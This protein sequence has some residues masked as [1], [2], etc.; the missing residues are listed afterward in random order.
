MTSTPPFRALAVVPTY[1]THRCVGSVSS[2]GACVVDMIR[3]L[4]LVVVTAVAWTASSCWIAAD[5]ASHKMCQSS[6]EPQRMPYDDYG[7]ILF[8][9]SRNYT[10]V[11]CNDTTSADE[12]EN[13]IIV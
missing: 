6:G 12:D 4:A 11:N 9:F 7:G 10:C 8:S 1:L 3:M 5:E 2:H 13:S